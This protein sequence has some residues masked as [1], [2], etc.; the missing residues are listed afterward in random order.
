M[1]V[2]TH[3]MTDQVRR[4]TGTFGREYTDRNDQTP[5]QLDVFYQNTYGKTRSE[6]NQRFLENVP[7]NVPILEVGCNV[8]TQ[9]LLLKEMGFTDLSGVEIQEYALQR[10]QERLGD[11]KILQAAALSIP[12]PDQQFELVFTSGVLIHIAPADLPIAMREIHR[13]TKKWVWGM[14]YYAPQMKEIVY[15]D[16]RNLLWK[17]DYARLYQHQCTEL[18]LV[19]EEDIPYLEGGNVDSMFLLERKG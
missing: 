7:R 5:R 15:R 14:E 3:E 12:F 17:A 10:A 9:L 18:E 6:L 13:C 8:G 4:W 16:N 11:A 19:R 1:T 2:N